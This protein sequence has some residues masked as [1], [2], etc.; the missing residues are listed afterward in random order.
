MRSPWERPDEEQDVSR[1]KVTLHTHAPPPPPIAASS[2][3]GGEQGSSALL[4]SDVQ[5]HAM[6][7]VSGIVGEHNAIKE[8]LREEQWDQNSTSSV[9]WCSS[10]A[11]AR[12]LRRRTVCFLP[13]QGLFLN[14]SLNCSV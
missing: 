8:G 13:R 10:R 6:E 9:P 5:E 4:A 1:V 7:S 11:R 3:M 2:S 12:S 14:A